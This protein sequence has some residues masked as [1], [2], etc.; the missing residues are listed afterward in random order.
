MSRR[1]GRRRSRG[2]RRVSPESPKQPSEKQAGSEAAQAPRRPRLRR[3]RTEPASAV[4]QPA[5]APRPRLRLLPKDGIVLEEVIS[6]MQEEFGTPA[7]PQEFRLLVKV[8]GA[9][10]EPVRTDPEDREEVPE[11]E[12][13]TPPPSEE[14]LEPRVRRFRRRRRRRPGPAAEGE[15]R[16]PDPRRGSPGIG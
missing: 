11:P 9:E 13:T 5:A 8:P 15:N 16:S 3:R 12:R 7:T 14:S 6:T 10:P 4:A 2:R 1:G